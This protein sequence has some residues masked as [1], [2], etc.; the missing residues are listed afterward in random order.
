MAVNVIVQEP[1][2]TRTA[3]NLATLSGAVALG[4]NGATALAAGDYVCYDNAGL[5]IKAKADNIATAAVGYVK[6]AYLAGATLVEIYQDGINTGQTIAANVTAYLSA[7]TAGAATATA[8]AAV[9]GNIVQPL[10][11]SSVANSI[12]NNVS[13]GEAVAYA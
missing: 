13:V 5:I 12:T 2:G 4:T 3:K 1:N 9:A 8:P 6:Q 11:Q 10:G 7:T